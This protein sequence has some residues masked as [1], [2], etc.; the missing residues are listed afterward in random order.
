MVETE[1]GHLIQS[2]YPVLAWGRAPRLWEEQKGPAPQY[3]TC[4][5]Y[6][7]DDGATWHYL[8]TVASPDRHPLPAQAEGYCEPDLLYLGD[9]RLLCVMRSGGSPTGRL[10]ERYTHLVACRSDDGG[11]TWT[12]PEPIAPYGVKPI[13][14]RMSSG[15]IACLAGRPGF[16]LVFSADEGKNWSTPL[17]VNESHGPWRR[18]ASGYGELIELEAGVLGV[19]YDGYRNS[20]EEGKMVARFRWYGVG[21]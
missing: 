16:F 1:D 21:R 17:W 10:M 18:A 9:G 13:L 7:R 2:A 12:P 4:V 5:I 6:S 11:L 14:L 8:S 19:A 15:L 3:R 20:G